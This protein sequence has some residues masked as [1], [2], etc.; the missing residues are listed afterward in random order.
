VEE[1]AQTVEQFMGRLSP[2]RRVA[3]EAVRATIVAELPSG[4]AESLDYGMLAYGVPTEGGR[5]LTLVSLA[6]H[7]PYMAL[8]VN[9]VRP[10]GESAFYE[11]WLACVGTIETGARAVKF[12]TLEEVALPA[13]AEFVRDASAEELRAAFAR[14]RAR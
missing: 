7:T 2:E 13:I 10:G 14:A 9:C 8:Y 11:R 5:S 3:A 12:R 1:P 6:D 4:F